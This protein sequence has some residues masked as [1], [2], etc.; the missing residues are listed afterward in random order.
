MPTKK[1]QDPYKTVAKA[2]KKSAKTAPKKRKLAASPALGAPFESKKKTI[3]EDVFSERNFVVTPASQ[4]PPSDAP[5]VMETEFGKVRIEGEVTPEK[6]RR[7]KEFDAIFQAA[8]SE[9]L[10]LA[11]FTPNPDTLSFVKGSNLTEAQTQEMLRAK[12]WS[13][14]QVGSRGLMKTPDNK[15]E[16]V[17]AYVNRLEKAVINVAKAKNDEIEKL[18][19]AN[20]ELDLKL[21]RANRDYTKLGDR[22]HRLEQDNIKLQRRLQDV[23]A[24]AV[25]NAIGEAFLQV[26]E[27]FGKLKAF[28]I[29][30]ISK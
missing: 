1:K 3:V 22:N 9:M 30:F 14:F 16:T 11:S 27:A 19:D 25:Q 29:N 8:T 26:K 5:V 6:M 23:P 17:E 4:E 18:L 13:V 10:D 20:K 24:F 15:L 7:A 2:T 28:V 12:P 21:R